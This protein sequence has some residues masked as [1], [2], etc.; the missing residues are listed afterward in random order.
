MEW[1]NLKSEK[2]PKCGAYLNK[3]AMYQCSLCDFKISF[4]KAFQI[5][6]KPTDLEKEAK[7]LLKKKKHW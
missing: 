6:G 7:L 3:G 1:E 4:G 5:V 2:C